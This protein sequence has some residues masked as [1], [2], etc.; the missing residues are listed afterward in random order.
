MELVLPQLHAHQLNINTEVV[1]LAHALSEHLFKDLNVKEA[2]PIA[3]TTK[4]KSATSIV[5]PA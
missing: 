5:L 4:A 3:L 2:A 1:V